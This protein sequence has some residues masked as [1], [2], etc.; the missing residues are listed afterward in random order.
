MALEGIPIN[1]GTGPTV[2]V[3]QS[4]TAHAQIVKIAQGGDGTFTLADTIAISGTASVT[5]VGVPAVT[6]ANVTVASVTT[7]TMHVTNVL[8]ATGVL[9]QAVTTG[10]M[11]VTNVLSATGVTIASITAVGP[12]QVG[13]ALI[14][15]GTGT[16]PLVMGI[17]SGA[18]LGRPILVT[19]TGSPVVTFA[20]TQAVTAAN[21]TIAS[22]T[23]GTMNVVN[24]LS[25]S[26]ITVASLTTGTMN[27]VNVL[28]ATGVLLGATTAGIGNVVSTRHA[29]RFQAFVLATTSAAGGVIVQT[30]GAHTLYITDL[31]ISVAGSMNVQVCSETTAM[32]QVYLPTTGGF[33]MDLTQPLVCTTAQSLRVILSSSGECGVTAVGY[34][35]T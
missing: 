33:V 15:S 31:L 16:G 20:G 27:V 4:G 25:A 26:G 35:V 7:G 34:T 30:S 28:S 8:S 24:V 23:T 1:S 10:T 14:A 19:T 6:A 29:Q 3:D 18:T 32:G 12:Y 22:V 9:V 5:F 21:V 13:G 11:H 2:L 17:Q